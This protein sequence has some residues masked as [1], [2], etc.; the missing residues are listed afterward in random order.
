MIKDAKITFHTN[1]CP[2]R[3]RLCKK[4]V[5]NSLHIPGVKRNLPISL[6]GIVVQTIH[7]KPLISKYG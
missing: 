4:K 5:R 3:V 7:V 6:G 1:M 2:K